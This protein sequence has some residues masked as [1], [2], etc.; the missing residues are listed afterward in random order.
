MIIKHSYLIF[1]LIISVFINAQKPPSYYNTTWGIQNLQEYNVGIIKNEGKYYV[2]SS[3]AKPNVSPVITVTILDSL[4][5][6]LKNKILSIS[7]K[8]LIIYGFNTMNFNNP[9]STIYIF[10]SINQ[11]FINNIRFEGMIWKIDKNLD[12]IW[13]K[14]YK[15]LSDSS[16]IFSGA[17]KQHDGFLVYGLSREY[18]SKGDACILKIDFNGNELWRKVYQV[19]SI[20]GGFA[21]YIKTK[22]NFYIGI[23]HLIDYPSWGYSDIKITSYDTLFNAI[24]SQIYYT[25]YADLLG[26]IIELS[27]SNY[28]YTSGY[29]HSQF[30]P[31]WG[32]LNTRPCIT[33]INK[34]NG[35]IIWQKK[36]AK[37]KFESQLF[38][39][40]ESPSKKLYALGN[41]VT[42]YS[43]NPSGTYISN[44]L[45]TNQYGDSL[46]YQEIFADSISENNELDALVPS[47]DGFKCVGRAGLAVYTGTAV[48]NWEYQNWLVKA[49]TN[50]CFNQACTNAVTTGLMGQPDKRIEEIN[51]YPNPASTIVNI[52]VPTTIGIYD[53]S[54]ECIIFDSNGK[55]L[56]KQPIKQKY[57]MLDVTKYSTGLYFIVITYNSIVRYKQKLILN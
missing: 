9:D 5:N 20:G 49:D 27:D 6:I 41:T 50:G 11:D 51:I 36:Y 54:F 32:S 7:N 23:E 8:G 48:T 12:T 25:P 31:P 24:W 29:C 52:I 39:V 42:A 43:I 4:N 19:P 15:N 34:N 13:H 55:Q 57:F 33:K 3:A 28:V 30:N 1:F 26:D 35:S 44:M 56:F 17:I 2:T 10:G 14:S 16:L 40:F 46:N 37:V 47:Y 21:K 22:S 18:D 53:N 38:N 45:V